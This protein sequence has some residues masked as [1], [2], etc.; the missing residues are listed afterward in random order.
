ML[1]CLNGCGNAENKGKEAESMN[2]SAVSREET[3]LY[4]AYDNAAYTYPIWEEGL[5]INETV[6]FVENE[7]DSVPPAPLLYT[8][9]TVI[10]VRSAT[11]VKSYEE[12][13]DYIIEG[14]TLVRTE[15]SH[16]PVMRYDEYYP[17][18]EIPGKT[19]ARTGGGYI[20]FS[21]GDFFHNRQVAITYEHADA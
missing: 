8:P 3:S 20:C 16:V 11:M 15:N 19:M 12:G 14:N 9:T 5:V 7:D 1:L 4:T 18:S 21:E 13:V 17:A 2:E 6:M 10:G